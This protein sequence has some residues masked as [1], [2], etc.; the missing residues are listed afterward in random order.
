MIQ[1]PTAIA[2]K[3]SRPKTQKTRDGKA[4]GGT[5]KRLVVQRDPETSKNKSGKFKRPR[6]HDDEGAGKL[7]KGSLVS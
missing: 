6:K 3:K 1:T 4:K 2:Q 7:S 5:Y